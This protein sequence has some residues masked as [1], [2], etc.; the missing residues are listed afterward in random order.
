MLMKRWML[1]FC[2]ALALMIPL[3]QSVR[4]V[5]TP[6]TTAFSYNVKLGSYAVQAGDFLWRI[7]DRYRTTVASIKEL[8]NLSTDMIDVGRQLAV[9]VQVIVSRKVQTPAP[10]PAPTTAGEVL[11]L[12]NAERAK[13]GLP[14][15]VDDQALA[16]VAQEKARDM[17][18]NGYFGHTSPTYG[19]PFAMMTKFGITYSYAAENIAQGYRDA[20][21]AVVGWMSSSG[22]RANILNPNL[23]H[24]GVG[25]DGNIWVQMFRKP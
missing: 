3:T 25:V 11:R 14:A 8:N 12:T 2:L 24:L 19:S 15:F 23:T 9:P 22:H 21:S 7:A 5:A 1:V 16:K 10:N 4:A 13:A 17:R 20:A 6:D 18:A